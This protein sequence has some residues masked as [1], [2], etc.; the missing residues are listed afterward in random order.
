V[1]DLFGARDTLSCSRCGRAGVVRFLRADA[2][3]ESYPEGWFVWRYGHASILAAVL[4]SEGCVLAWKTK[5][6]QEQAARDA[7]E[8]AA[9]AAVASFVGVARDVVDYF[10]FKKK[11]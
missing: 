11:R 7:H 5:L 4:C 10:K 1:S 9:R 2:C 8:E 3:C 6:D